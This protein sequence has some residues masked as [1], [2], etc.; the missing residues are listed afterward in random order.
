[1]QTPDLRRITPT[2]L[3]HPGL[4]HLSQGAV[5]LEWANGTTDVVT[6][7]E[8]RYRCPC[9]A[10]VNEHTGKRILTRAEVRPNVRPEKVESAG[11][12]ALR[13]HWSDGHKTGLYA[14]ETLWHIARLLEQEGHV[15]PQEAQGPTTT[16]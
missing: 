15:K 2:Q 5:S 7:R 12:Y 8:L 4:E 6:Y 9:A 10:C 16:P 14:F 11:R 3:S 13:F 1:M